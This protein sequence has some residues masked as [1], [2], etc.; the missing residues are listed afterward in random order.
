MRPASSVSIRVRSGA[1]FKSSGSVIAETFLFIRFRLVLRNFLATSKPFECS[2]FRPNPNV[3][4]HNLRKFVPQCY[5]FKS[6]AQHPS[7]I[8]LRSGIQ[9]G[10]TLVSDVQGP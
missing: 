7:R 6:S 1:V 10:G 4:L 2:G 8:P 5:G 3:S 9:I